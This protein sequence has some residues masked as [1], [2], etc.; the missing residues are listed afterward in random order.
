MQRKGR[1][2][3]WTPEQRDQAYAL[4][5]EGMP[6]RA[7]SKQVFGDERYRGR[8]ER[9]LRERHI[10]RP[11][12]SLEDELAASVPLDEVGHELAALDVTGVRALLER[13]ERSLREREE[14]PS[15]A[16][17]ERLIRIK[18]QLDTM[19]TIERHRARIRSR[20]ADASDSRPE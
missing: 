2:P 5:D 7:I 9:I 6:Q 4:A 20:R 13:F 17:I 8:V 15:L 1:P 11:A 10:A 19:E 3:T 14:V 12:P 16:D 18:R